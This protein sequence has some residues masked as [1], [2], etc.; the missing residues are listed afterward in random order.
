MRVQ[1]RGFRLGMRL[2]LTEYFEMYNIKFNIET[3]VLTFA[4]DTMVLTYAK[5]FTK[6]EGAINQ[7]IRIIKL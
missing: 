1:K 3:Q 7:D 6:A 4:D 2:L 5:I